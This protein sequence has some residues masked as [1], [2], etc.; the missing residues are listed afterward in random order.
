MIM[1]GKL[2][3]GPLVRRQHLYCC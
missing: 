3:T 1:T 2:P